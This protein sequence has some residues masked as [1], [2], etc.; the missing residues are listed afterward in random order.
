[1]AMLKTGPQGIPLSIAAGITGALQLA[2]AI[3][4][5]LPQFA[6]GTEDAPGGWAITDERGPEGYELP[7]GRK[8]IGSNDG[9][10][11]RYLPK[12][13]KVIPHD[14]MIQMSTYSMMNGYPVLPR[15]DES[16]IDLSEVVNE[17]KDS[18]AINK[19][20]LK[21]LIIAVGQHTKTT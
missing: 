19:Q 12:H 7:D 1:M 9:P 18:K 5:P 3:A 8:F 13:T 20:I 11:L 14:E 2:K 15:Y 6:D 4:T 10:T 21:Q 16:K 17:L